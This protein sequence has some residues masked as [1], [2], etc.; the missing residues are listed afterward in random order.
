S[1]NDSPLSL[2][3]SYLP[4]STQHTVLTTTQR[5]LEE[6][7]FDFVKRWLPSIL[8]DNGWDCAAA[9]E[10]TKWTRILDKHSE[11]LPNHA[12]AVSGGSFHDILFS[13]HKLRHSAVHRLPTAAR[14]LNQLIDSALR[15]TEALQDHLRVAQLEELH[16]EIGSK[17][18]AM[19]LNKNAL[20]DELASELQKISRQREE[21]DEKERSLRAKMLSSDSENM[22][23]IRSLL[24]ESVREI[25]HE[26]FEWHSA[27]ED[28]GDDSEDH[29]DVEHGQFLIE[30]SK[31]Y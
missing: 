10:L 14:G 2:Y 3:P 27:V 4:Y 8:Q 23:L 30:V 26:G 20:E 22:R 13:T 31:E 15:L 24:E 11:T 5:I 18:K 16:L 29:N 19:E 9:V 28:N 1:K 6:C 12:L 17:I 21:L 7:C 25:F